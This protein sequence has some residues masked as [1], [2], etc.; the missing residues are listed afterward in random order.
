MEGIDIKVVAVEAVRDAFKDLGMSDEMVEYC[1][2]EVIRPEVLARMKLEKQQ[3]VIA[4]YQET[5]EH[6]IDMLHD[7][8][9]ELDEAALDKFWFAS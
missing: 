3:E 7:A 2:A 4:A 9:D 6:L 8:Y 5:V 1:L